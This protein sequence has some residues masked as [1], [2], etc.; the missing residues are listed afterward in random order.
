D[1]SDAPVIIWIHGG[2]LR[3]GGTEFATYD[4]T[5]FA[6]RG[7]VFVSINYRLG[8]LGWLAHPGLSAES[9]DGVSGNY[10]LQD[11]IAALE[12]VEENIEAFGGDAGNVTIMG[13]SAGALSV[14]YLLTS[15]AAEGLF[16]KAIMQSVGSRTF[17]ALDQFVYGLPPAEQKGAELLEK[18]GY[19]TIEAAREADAQSLINRSTLQQ[20]TAEGT[21]DGR[22][23]TEQLIE[24]FDSGAHQK[25]PVIAGFNSGEGRTYAMWLPPLPETAEAYE[26]ALAKSYPD[27]ADDIIAV[28][29]SDDIRESSLGMMRDS[30]F[31]WAGERIVRKVRDAGQPAYL[32]VFD[33]CYPSA[34]ER[35]LCAFHGS[36]VPYVFGT[37][38]ADELPATWPTPDAPGDDALSEML[39]DYWTSFAATGEP[40]SEEGPAWLSYGDA[41]NYLHIEETPKASTDPYPGMFEVHETVVEGLRENDEAWFFNIEVPRRAEDKE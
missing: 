37:L 3:I 25:V 18:L 10:G 19:E 35:D 29:P 28:Y 7:I 23:L 40:V 21:I 12:W 15:P 38:E 30:I 2:S 1:A 8:L 16:D 13:E 39:L 14:A 31:G 22:F 27:I 34:R 6:E 5:K 24:A 20:F 41:E 11:Q 33:H 4:G 9:P 17:S 36:E 26:A 32:Y